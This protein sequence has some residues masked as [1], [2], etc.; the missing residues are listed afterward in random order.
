[1]I[2]VEVLD[3]VGDLVFLLVVALALVFACSMVLDLDLIL[4]LV[5]FQ[6]LVQVWFLFTSESGSHHSPSSGPEKKK[7]LTSHTYAHILAM[8]LQDQSWF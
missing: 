5:L 1:M 7:I 2:L 6:G 8:S 3:L 4:V